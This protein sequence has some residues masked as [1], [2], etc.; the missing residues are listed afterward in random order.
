MPAMG[1]EKATE[2]AAVVGAPV[3]R[4]PG[5]SRLTTLSLVRNL[6]RD[7]VRFFQELWRR[8]GDF[9]RIPLGHRTFYVL[10]DAD[11]I[12]WVLRANYRNYKKA[13]MFNDERRSAL[14]DSLLTSHDEFWLRQRR[15][16]Q[17]AFQPQALNSYV[18]SMARIA[19]EELDQWRARPGS[20]PFEI[21]APLTA[22]TIRIASEVLFGVD[23]RDEA[24]HI[25]SSVHAVVDVGSSRIAA[26]TKMPLWWP[27]RAHRRFRRGLEYLDELVYRIVDRRANDASGMDVLSRLIRA[28]DEDTG[29]GM[30]R[31]ALRDEVIT[32]LIAGHE[33]TAAGLAW[34]AYLVGTHPDVEERLRAEVREVLGDRPP[35]VADLPKLEYTSWVVQEAMRLYPPSWLFDREAVDADRLG[36]HE[37]PAGAMLLIVPIVL[38][39]HPRY[40]IDP[41]RFDPLRFQP[42]RTAARHPFAYV[43]FS[44]GPRQCIGNRFALIE[45][46]IVT[47]MMAQRFRVTVVPEHPIEL[48]AV[49]ALR[50]KHGVLVRLEPIHRGA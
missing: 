16:S 35:S 45:S 10:N 47:A 25:S 26:V 5:P 1:D 4:P 37:L 2:R 50:P 17:P 12:E 14:G 34:T 46:I 48:M 15:L 33:S 38:H 31:K 6:Q 32:F 49:I 13:A 18:G 8:Y 11:H 21:G 42:E 40:W 41:E 43:P 24:E 39:R 7:R 29:A 19:G 23:L 22:I 9:V 3:M 20:Q 30:S 27:S 44:A 28:R 36:N